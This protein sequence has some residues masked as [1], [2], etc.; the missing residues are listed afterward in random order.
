MLSEEIK[1][2]NRSCP[3]VEAERDCI[4]YE[5][6]TNADIIRR[7]SDEE[8]AELMDNAGDFFLCDICEFREPNEYGEG[9]IGRGCK[10][11]ILKWL[12]TEIE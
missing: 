1:K 10:D 6:M 11:Y 5:C 8:L 12:K 7:M 3:D 4:E 9:C 2:I